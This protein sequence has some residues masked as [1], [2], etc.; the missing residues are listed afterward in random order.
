MAEKKNVIVNKKET[1]EIVGQLNISS[2]SKT[3]SYED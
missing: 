3:K 2:H 1:N